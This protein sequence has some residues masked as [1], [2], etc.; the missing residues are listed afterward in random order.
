MVI[1]YFNLPTNNDTLQRA[2]DFLQ[3]REGSYLD[4]ILK[5]LD[6]FGLA[7]R[8]VKVDLNRPLNLPIPSLWVDTAGNCQLISRTSNTSISVIDPRIGYVQLNEK[9]AT[10]K[11]SI[12]PE[13]LSIDVGLHTPQKRFDI[14]WLLPYIKRYRY[15]LI[16]VFSA[17]FL[18]QIFALATPLLFQQIIDRVISKGAADALTPLAI[19]MLTC[20]ILEVTFSILRTFQFVEIS[21]V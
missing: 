15:Q 6:R 18:N 7:V 9:E 3:S 12:T 21:N 11:F 2:A 16:E 14:F 13:I 17:S 1:D 19:L 4:D 8:N 10:E 5:I 20:A